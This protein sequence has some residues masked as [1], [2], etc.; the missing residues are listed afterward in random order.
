MPT[1][2]WLLAC[3]SMPTH[4]QQLQNNIP[5]STFGKPC[6]RRAKEA[7]TERYSSWK[8]ARC[9]CS[10]CVALDSQPFKPDELA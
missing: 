3:G 7:S 5:H 2:N 10:E 8:I 6:S 9:I 1:M 4:S